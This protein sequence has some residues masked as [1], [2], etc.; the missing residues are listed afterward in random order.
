MDASQNPDLFL[1]FGNLLVEDIGAQVDI[2]YDTTHD[3]YFLNSYMFDKGRLI[4]L[5]DF[6]YD[7]GLLSSQG[8]VVQAAAPSHGFLTEVFKYEVKFEGAGCHV[9]VL[10]R[11]PVNR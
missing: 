6:D 3:Q 10:Q 5:Y 1:A 9:L 8:A 7:A 11:V 2:S 4:G